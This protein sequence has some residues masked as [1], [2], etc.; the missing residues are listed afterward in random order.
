MPDSHFFIFSGG[1]PSAKELSRY[2][3]MALALWRQ[4]LCKL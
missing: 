1:L 4:D 2:G 3:T